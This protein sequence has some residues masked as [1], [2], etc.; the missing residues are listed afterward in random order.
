MFQ[1]YAFLLS[2]GHMEHS[3]VGILRKTKSIYG[4]HV[5]SLKTKRR[6]VLKGIFKM[7]S[8]HAKHISTRRSLNQLTTS[9]FAI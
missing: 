3:H 9:A 6:N 8:P 4:I 5:Q 2:I 1:F 7:G